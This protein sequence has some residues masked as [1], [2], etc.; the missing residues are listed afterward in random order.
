[1][2]LNYLVPRFRILRHGQGTM[3]YNEG[4]R[5][6]GEW[7]H[8]MRNGFG[9]L[10]T[11]NDFSRFSGHFIKNKKV[12][13]GLHIFTDGTYYE[14]EYSEDQR[15]GTGS[16]C[17]PNGDKITGNFQ[18][19]NVYKAEF[20]KAKDTTKVTPTSRALLNKAMKAPNLSEE[21]LSSPF[22][23]K[24]Y[25][26][27]QP[28]SLPASSSPE[29]VQKFSSSSPAILQAME[30][31]IS[32][33]RWSYSDVDILQHDHTKCAL[34]SAID[35]VHSFTEEILDGISGQVLIDAR[36][37]RKLRRRLVDTVAAQIYPTLFNLYA[38]TYRSQ[39]ALLLAQCMAFATITP[40]RLGVSE[41]FCLQSSQDQTQPT[42]PTPVVTPKPEIEFKETFSEFSRSVDGEMISDYRKFF[43]EK[44]TDPTL[45]T[46]LKVPDRVKKKE[47]R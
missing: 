31:F 25:L 7:K 15:H 44:A 14:G 46:T 11:L 39:D 8:D 28:F 40:E 20:I 22:R 4:D 47:I 35:E 32:T 5:Y 29:Q 12:G 13:Y 26:K 3:E 27:H 43:I 23:W 2:K 10:W 18:N 34:A 30:Q 45:Q 16:L 33:F 1:V 17:F 24:G 41:P 36:L 21:P 19:D 37:R 6:Y 38:S 42:T 9:I